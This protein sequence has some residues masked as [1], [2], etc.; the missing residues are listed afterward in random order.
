MTHPFFSPA[1]QGFF[2]EP[3]NIA[4]TAIVGGAVSIYTISKLDVIKS[5]FGYFIILL[6]LCT[7]IL[8][9]PQFQGTNAGAYAEQTLALI[10]ELL[11][12]IITWIQTNTGGIT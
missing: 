6:G 11:R 3:E 7:V 1:I 10:Q 4:L 5:L 9:I 2:T 12:A 8:I